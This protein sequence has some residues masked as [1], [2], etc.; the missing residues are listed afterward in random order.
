V[1]SSW[2]FHLLIY[3]MHGTVKLKSQVAIKALDNFHLNF[4]IVSE[5][6]QILVIL[7]E[8]NRIQLVWVLSHMGIDGH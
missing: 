8:H 5:C 4:K 3:M 1:A 7:A 6:H 2:C